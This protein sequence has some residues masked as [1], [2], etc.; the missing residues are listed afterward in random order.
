[1]ASVQHYKIET[2]TKMFFLWKMMYW[3]NE[4][5]RNNMIECLKNYET[6]TDILANTNWWEKRICT[7]KVKL[8]K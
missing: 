3:V 8:Y 5:I 6:Y 7:L 4:W 1:M 2:K